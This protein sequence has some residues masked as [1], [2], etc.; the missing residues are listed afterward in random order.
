MR[1]VLDIPYQLEVLCIIAIRHKA[2]ETPPHPIKELRWEQIH[3]E[4]YSLPE[5]SEQ[6]G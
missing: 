3:L 1:N 5:E 2:H 4:R 6:E